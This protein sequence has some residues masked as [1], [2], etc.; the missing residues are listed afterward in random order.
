VEYVLDNP[1]SQSTS[2]S[3]SR[4]CCFG[5]T[6]SAEHIIVVYEMISDEAAYPVTAYH[7][8]EP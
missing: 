2:D 1:V 3:S 6:S 4:P 5:Y 8:P 7:V